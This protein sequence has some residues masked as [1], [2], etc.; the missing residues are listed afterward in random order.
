MG[1]DPRER[2]WRSDGG[3]LRI[4]SG[5]FSS[6][7]ESQSEPGAAQRRPKPG[8]T[9]AQ[10]WPKVSRIR[11]QFRRLRPK[12]GPT[13]AQRRPKSGPTRRPWPKVSRILAPFWR[14][15]AREI[16]VSTLFLISLLIRIVV[17]EKRG[18]GCKERGRLRPF[19]RSLRQ[20]NPSA[21]ARRPESRR[22]RPGG[23]LRPS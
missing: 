13:M 14:K 2:S 10:R 4:R 5:P 23:R 15:M 18:R 12:P 3:R 7:L 11:R 22:L 17:R 20:R 9:M 6:P 8:P 16:L 1:R 21:S 19:R